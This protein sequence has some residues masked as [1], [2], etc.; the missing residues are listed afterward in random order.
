MIPLWLFRV[1]LGVLALLG[2]W[3]LLLFWLLGFLGI[4][5]FCSFDFWAFRF[6]IFSEYWHSC[7]LVYGWR[8]CGSN[9]KT[10]GVLCLFLSYYTTFPEVFNVLDLLDYAE[11]GVKED[12]FLIVEIPADAAAGGCSCLLVCL[13]DHYTSA[14]ILY[15]MLNT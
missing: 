1:F 14:E 10:E 13:R 6:F 8:G 2:F 11:R 15:A 7:I 5:L 12:K 3:T 4:W 9:H